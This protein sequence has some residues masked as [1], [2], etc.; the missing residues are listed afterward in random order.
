MTN[1]KLQMTNTIISYFRKWWTIIIRPIYF[2]TKLKDQDWR[3]GAMSFFLVTA[4]IL[5]FFATL[6][7]FV[8]QYIPVGSTLVSGVSGAKLVIVLP[9]LLTLILVFFGIT[10]LI[11]GGLFSFAFFVLLYLVAWCLHYV[12]MF[13]GGKGNVNRMLQCTLYSGA[14]VLAGL[15]ILFLMALTKYA[16]LPFDLFKAG[17]NFFYLMILIYVYGLW[18]VAGRKVYNVPKWK[19]FAGA[20]VPIFALLIFGFVFDKMVLPKLQ[21]WIT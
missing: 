16:G 8:I 3:E 13:L 15:I 17:Y 11:L 6:L 14:I 4:W 2:Y 12:Y 5:G 10:F 9:V 7:V 20:I 19:A 21:P 18:A 1:D